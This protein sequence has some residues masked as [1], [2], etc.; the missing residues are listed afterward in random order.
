[1]LTKSLPAAPAALAV[2]PAGAKDLAETVARAPEAKTGS[3][4]SVEQI[5]EAVSRYSNSKAIFDEM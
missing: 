2:L 1:M 3:K 5:N 4:S